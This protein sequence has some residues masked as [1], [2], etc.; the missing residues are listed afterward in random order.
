MPPSNAMGT[1]PAA[2]LVPQRPADSMRPVGG[3]KVRASVIIPTLNEVK[4]LPALMEALGPDVRSRHGLE[5][6]VSDG[7]STD[8]TIEVA[9]GFAD[10]LVE[11]D[12]DVRQTIAAGRNAGAAVAAGGVLMFVNA[13]VTLPDDLNAFLA[14]M[15]AAA[16]SSGAATCRV[17]VHP[18]QA[19]LQDRAVLGTCNAAYY[20]W[21]KLRLGMGRGECQAVRC[22][23][24]H[25]AG[26]YNGNLVAGE[27]F[28]LYRRIATH[29]R[30]TGASRIQFLWKWTL[31][32]DPRRYRQHGYVRTL[33]TWLRN[34]V[35]VTFLG[36]AHSKIWAP[37]R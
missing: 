6:I 9:R 29:G 8:G 4:V 25:A 37:V 27:D 16:E 31:W 17:A 7:G 10:I 5:I 14:D 19:T 12:G 35:Y 18:E 22:D 20:L 21:N 30:H 34:S 23:V 28:D 32:E 3:G 13:D 36:R 24:F 15:L 1:D 26:G 11:H 33:A 2:V